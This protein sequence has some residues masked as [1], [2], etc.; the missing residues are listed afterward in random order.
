[1]DTK[2]SKI[3]LT[4][5]AAT[6]LVNI[7]DSGNESDK[8][9]SGNIR[10]KLCFKHNDILSISSDIDSDDEEDNVTSQPIA[11]EIDTLPDIQ[12]ETRNTMV[13]SNTTRECCNTMDVMMEPS[14]R[15]IIRSILLQH[16]QTWKLWH[17]SKSLTG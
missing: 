7:N 1:M 17:S 10:K 13:N 6:N 16:E 11:E 5:S 14:F 8:S 15:T 4:K 2:V 12:I 9:F 3:N